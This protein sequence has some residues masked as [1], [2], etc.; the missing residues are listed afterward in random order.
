MIYIDD[1][2]G[3][4]DLLPLLP[5]NS[6][7]LTRLEYGDASFL[8]RGIDDAPVSIGVERKRINDL[9][10]S[11]TSGRLSGHQLIGL[12]ACYDVT[13]IVVEGLW[14]A[15]PQSGILE[16]PRRGGWGPVQLG[17]RTFMSKEVWSFLNTLQILAGVYIWKSGSARATAQW[18]VNLYHWWNSKPVDAH[19]SHLAPHVGCVQLTTKRPSLVQRVAAEL[20][21]VGFERSKAVAKKFSTLMELVM[22]T[23]DEWRSIDGIGK[24]LTKRIMEEIH[25]QH[26]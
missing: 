26:Q 25:A 5:N 3:S 23:E 20:G 10:N 4:C 21:G 9:L 18:L 13:Y 2:V 24:T 7:S 1:R 6:A 19:K 17:A 15:N 22:A 8:G 16:K 12:T 14:R 11:M